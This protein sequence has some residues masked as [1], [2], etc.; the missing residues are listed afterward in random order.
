VN[1]QLNNS[2]H[3]VRR[4]SN[5]Q[6][7]LCIASQRLPQNERQLAV[8]IRH[9]TFFRLCQRIDAVAECREWLVDFLCLFESLTR[10]TSFSDLFTS[11]Q[12]GQ[13]QLA[14][15]GSS[16]TWLLAQWQNE[17][18][19][20]MCEPF[21]VKQR[22]RIIYLW[23]RELTAFICVL[24]TALNFSPSLIRSSTSCSHVTN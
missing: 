20:V 13:I 1:N 12:I 17:Q 21:V 23:D 10:S 5:Y 14:S 24:L 22:D 8:S 7:C 9:V 18:T 3:S 2:T 11:S 6:S 19:N 15:F 4:A 16:I